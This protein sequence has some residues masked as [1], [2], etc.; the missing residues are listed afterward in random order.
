[1]AKD[2]KFSALL[3]NELC[4]VWLEVVINPLLLFINKSGQI[5]FAPFHQK[6]KLDVEIKS[7]KYV[8]LPAI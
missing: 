1:M 5:C 3:P 2:K 7:T 4:R 6:K 8:N